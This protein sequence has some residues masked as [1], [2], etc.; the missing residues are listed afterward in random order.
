MGAPAERKG[1]KS[2]EELTQTRGFPL[3]YRAPSPA[4]ERRGASPSL[5]PLPQAPPP[6]TSEPQA[7]GGGQQSPSRAPA[8][9]RAGEP[10][11]QRRRAAGGGRQPAARARRQPPRASQPAPRRGSRRYSPGTHPAH[12]PGRPGGAARSPQ[13][14]DTLPQ[15]WEWVP[16]RAGLWMGRAG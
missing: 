8:R 7:G 1:R 4:R 2:P 5:V 6:L 15:G 11:A 13:S 12:A 14:L 9:E 16:G 10:G 3:N